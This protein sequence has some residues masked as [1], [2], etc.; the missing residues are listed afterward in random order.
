VIVVFIGIPYVLYYGV[1][2]AIKWAEETAKANAKAQEEAADLELQK[3][4]PEV[5]RNQQLLKL[6]KERLAA[7]QQ[8]AAQQ[9]E[10]QKKHAE[11]ENARRNV[12]LA[13]DIFGIFLRR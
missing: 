13:A 4:H 3:S 11:Q 2:F 10:A 9:L 5:W 6:E 12:G 1:G 8:L 7:Q